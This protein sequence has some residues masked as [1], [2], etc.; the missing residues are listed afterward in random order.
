MLALG[1][2]ADE[3]P[4]RPALTGYRG[5]TVIGRLTRRELLHR[6]AAVEHHLFTALSLRAG[7]RLAV[8]ATNRLEIPVLYLAAMRLGAVLVPLNPTSPAEHWRFGV[9]HAGA[10]LLVADG[11]L[12]PALP[13]M[14]VP[15]CRLEEA[16]P[17]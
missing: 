9:E 8:L 6:V 12:L 1:R 7:D 3:A 17:T 10:R 13:Q 4:E 5:R 15:A 16:V 11:D 2:L 14:P